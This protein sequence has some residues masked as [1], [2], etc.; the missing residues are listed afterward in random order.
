M[1]YWHLEQT[2]TLSEYSFHKLGEEVHEMLKIPTK[3]LD[4]NCDQIQS[5]HVE[6]YNLG[7]ALSCTGHMQE[8]QMPWSISKYIPVRNVL[9]DTKINFLRLY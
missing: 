2:V 5:W 6:Q 8:K 3:Q 4:V 1:T 9:C 7:T